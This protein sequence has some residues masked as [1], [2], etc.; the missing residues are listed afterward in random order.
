MHQFLTAR[1]RRKSMSPPSAPDPL[2]TLRQQ[3]EAL[4]RECAELSAAQATAG[5]VRRS[6]FLAL[7]LFV[8]VTCVSFYRLA[9][10]FVHQ[11]NVDQLV[12]VAERRLGENSKDYLRQVETLV[13]RTR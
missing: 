8:V 11:D 12:K 10:R 7:L 4:E 3:V 9:N 13:D 6:I 1:V 5:K 2:E